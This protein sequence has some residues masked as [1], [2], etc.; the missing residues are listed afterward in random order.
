MCFFVRVKKVSN[1]LLNN[2]KSWIYSNLSFW[3]WFESVG[4]ELFWWIYIFSSL[5]LYWYESHSLGRWWRQMFFLLF[6]SLIKFKQWKFKCIFWNNQYWFWKSND[7][8]TCFCYFVCLAKWVGKKLQSE[9]FFQIIFIQKRLKLSSL[10]IF[11]YLYMC[12]L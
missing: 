6:N 7:E 9:S 10:S 3:D 8:R 4:D 1:L 5:I 2:Q 11:F 12:L